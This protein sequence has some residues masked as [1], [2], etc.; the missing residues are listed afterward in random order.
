MAEEKH[1]GSLAWLKP[2]AV[3]RETQGVFDM[4]PA[5]VKLFVYTNTAATSMMENPNFDISSFD[6]EKRPGILS[7]VELDP[8]LDNAAFIPFSTAEEDFLSD[9]VAP[10][11]LYVRTTKGTE[12]ETAD[13]LRTA[14]MG[15]LDP[16]K[17]PPTQRFALSDWD[18]FRL[19]EG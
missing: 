4:T 11:K 14:A 10:T 19:G 17:P 3:D 18:P 1:Y 15:L 12:Q 7:N 2:G 8:T 9:D 6:R 5:D 13:A 16:A